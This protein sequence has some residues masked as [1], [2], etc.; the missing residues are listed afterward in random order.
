MTALKNYSVLNTASGIVFLDIFSATAYR[1]LP[2][3]S[4]PMG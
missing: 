2:K 4:I 1:F 3:S